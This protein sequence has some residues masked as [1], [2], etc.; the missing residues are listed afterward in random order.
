MVK[1]IAVGN[2]LYGDDGV[3]AAV[4]A[5][6][7]EENI[8]PGAELVDVHTDAL[9]IIDHFTA[10]DLHVIIDAAKMGE[11]PGRV[12]RFTPDE[13][14]LRI[15]WDHLSIHGFGLAETFSIAESIGEMPERVVIIGVEP[16]TIQIDRG[17]TDAVAAAVPEVIATIQAEVQG[18]DAEDHPRR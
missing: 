10:D 17:L 2:P 12:V 3:G 11:Q 4:L 9:A 7:G 13:V 18:D 15:E 16:E 6:L 14:R 8:L 5:K 1:V